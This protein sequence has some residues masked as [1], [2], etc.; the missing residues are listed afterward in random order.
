MS[1][2]YSQAKIYMIK[3]NSDENYL[4]YIGSTCK[5][6][7]SQRMSEHRQRFKRFK[8]GKL[9]PQD[10]SVIMMFRRFGV[11]NCYIELVENFPCS[12]KDELN[13]RL[14]SLIVKKANCCNDFT[15][16]EREERKFRLGN[17]MGN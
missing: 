5:K 9:W 6:L 8:D 10:H 16:K 13:D 15:R 11:E 2:D 3:A 17:N 14:N 7:L 4:P 12:N 1:R